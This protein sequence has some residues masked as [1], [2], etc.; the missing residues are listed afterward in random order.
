[1]RRVRRNVVPFPAATRGDAPAGPRHG[2]GAE[3]VDLHPVQPEHVQR[4]MS[5]RV[6]MALTIANMSDARV[7]ALAEVWPRLMAASL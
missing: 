4:A 1:M 7:R 2:P 3:V 6:E 5:L